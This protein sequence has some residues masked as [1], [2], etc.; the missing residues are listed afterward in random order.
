MGL[1]PNWRWI[2][3]F[4]RPYP[5]N[6]LRENGHIHEIAIKFLIFP[7][8][9]L[10]AWLFMFLCLMAKLIRGERQKFAHVAEIEN[11]WLIQ[12]LVAVPGRFPVT[13]L[14]VFLLAVVIVK[15]GFW[16]H[17]PLVSLFGDTG[18]NALLLT[19]PPDKLELGRAYAY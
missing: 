2:L 8:A 11:P 3:S 5:G 1:P 18:I 16:D 19:L 15:K 13:N 4:F 10:G 14:R 17:P 6:P 12:E 7:D 9:Y